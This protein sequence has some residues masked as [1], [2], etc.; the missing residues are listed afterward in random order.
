MGEEP[1]LSIVVPMYNLG[2]WEQDSLGSL[3]AQTSRTGWEAV[4]VETMARGMGRAQAWTPGCVGRGVS[5]SSISPIV[6]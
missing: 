2:A 4:V 5:A 1:L 3:A 6:G